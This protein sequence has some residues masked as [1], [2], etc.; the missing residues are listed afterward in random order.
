MFQRYNLKNFGR[1]VR[2]LC[3]LSCRH[4]ANLH[5]VF[6]YSVVGRALFIS[7]S[8]FAADVT[9]AMLVD[10]NKA[11][12][13]AGRRGRQKILLLCAPTWPPCHVVAAQ[14]IT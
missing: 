1:K 5:N 9:A 2:Y 13:S 4:L 11:F 6:N 7:N 10:K 8:W 12:D 3:F 14:H